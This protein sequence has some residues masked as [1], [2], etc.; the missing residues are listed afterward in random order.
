[1]T[2]P[3]YFKQTN[4]TTCSLAVLR[5]V[6]AAYNITVSENELLKKVEKDYGK[7]FKNLWNPTIA[8]IARE[9]GIDATMYAL[10]PLFKKDILKTASKE[11]KKNP[12]QFT[13][14]KYEN[15]NDTAVFSEPLLLAYKEMFKA[16]ES[17]CKTAYG[18]LTK[19]RIKKLLSGGYLIQT[20]IRLERMY[21]NQK[22]GHH[23]ILL[24]NYIGDTIYYH[25]PY[26]GASLRCSFEHQSKAS[27]AVG[28]AIA[29]KPFL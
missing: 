27:T 9:Y 26:R 14:S 16:I 21:P 18:S 13:I 23:S 2:V 24:Y 11:Y 15:K 5:M 6:L 22:K 17:G 29:F 19:A 8:K 4:A 25:D 28:A 20:S 12:Q 7:N 10:W 1:M 3:P